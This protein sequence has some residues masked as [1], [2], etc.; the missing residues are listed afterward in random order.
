M[1]LDNSSASESVKKSGAIHSFHVPG[2]AVLI[3]KLEQFI[4]ISAK[5]SGEEE[6]L[7]LQLDK[8]DGAI[9]LVQ[10]LNIAS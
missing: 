7:P 3:F 8:S 10:P 5:Q 6:V 9:K 4:Y 2:F 1:S